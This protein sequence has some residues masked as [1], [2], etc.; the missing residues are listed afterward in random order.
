MTPALATIAAA[1]REAEQRQYSACNHCDHHRWLDAELR[2]ACPALMWAEQPRPVHL[3]RRP[4]GGCGPEALHM[5][6]PWLRQAA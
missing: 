6:A 3:V 2:C 4:Q 5:S 1:W